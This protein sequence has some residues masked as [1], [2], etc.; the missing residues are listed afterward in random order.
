MEF[1]KEFNIVI[2][3]IK[4]FFKN[5]NYQELYLKNDVIPY[6]DKNFFYLKYMNDNVF[7]IVEF[8]LNGDKNELR[9]IEMEL[10]DYLEF[11]MTQDENFKYELNY[12]KSDN[13]NICKKYNV[14]KLENKHKK[15]IEKD[16]GKVFFL[17][18]FSE[19]N[20]NKI[21]VIIHGVDTII[22]EEKINRK[23]LNK[24]LDNSLFLRSGG[25]INLSEMISAMKLSGLI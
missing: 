16:F 20:V 23:E 13:S 7:P 8:Q 5:K 22:S 25:Y 1:N 6:T 11:N 14:K 19:K 17:E 18:N 24:F 10:L 21:D 4:K 2:N 15:I 3:Q 9:K 12:P